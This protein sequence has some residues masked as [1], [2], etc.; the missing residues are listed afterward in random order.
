M[1]D[2]QYINQHISPPGYYNDKITNFSLHKIVGD[3]KRGSGNKANG[4]RKPPYKLNLQKFVN[5]RK[6]HH[7]AIRP[8]Q[9]LNS[10][11]ESPYKVPKSDKKLKYATSGPESTADDRFDDDI[12]ESEIVT[13]PVNSIPMMI[14]KH[15]MPKVENCQ[16]FKRADRMVS[17]DRVTTTIINTNKYGSI[18][19]REKDRGTFYTSYANERS[20]LNFLKNIAMRNER[21][22][23]HQSRDVRGL[24]RF[25]SQ[26][27]FPKFMDNSAVLSSYIR[28]PVANDLPKYLEEDR[29]FSFV[30][31]W[32]RSQTRVSTYVR[33]DLD[34][35]ES[36]N[37]LYQSYTDNRDKHRSGSR[38]RSERISRRTFM[39]D[40]K[41]QTSK[42]DMSE[43]IYNENDATSLD[44]TQD[45]TKNNRKVKTVKILP[46]NHQKMHEFKGDSYDPHN[47]QFTNNIA[48]ANSK[49]QILAKVKGFV[50]KLNLTVKKAKLRSDACKRSKFFDTA[51]LLYLVNIVQI[52]KSIYDRPNDKLKQ[53]KNMHVINRKI[54]AISSEINEKSKMYKYIAPFIQKAKDIINEFCELMQQQK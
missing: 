48:T 2:Q 29:D 3:G 46:S 32:A 50:S 30:A 26:I 8:A 19:R 40:S 7:E 47:G 41:Q 18:D 25:N 14:G 9:T 13:S 22:T 35:K 20:G 34:A 51:S 36:R 24:Y 54:N 49:A 28:P 6:T 53:P 12:D 43:V 11:R 45:S 1:E 21:R 38:L 27:D 15:M 39:N 23:E 44:V 10:A 4:H 42:V 37:I 52:F 17:Q 33:V 31:K 16:V 5:S